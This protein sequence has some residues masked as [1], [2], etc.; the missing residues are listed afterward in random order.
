MNVVIAIMGD[1]TRPLAARLLIA[2]PLT[3][4]HDE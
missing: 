4:K 1:N 3:T 2:Y